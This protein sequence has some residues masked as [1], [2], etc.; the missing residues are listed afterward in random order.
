MVDLHLYRLLVSTE[1]GTDWLSCGPAADQDPCAR[2]APLPNHSPAC[3]P[4]WST[5]GV[6]EM[7]LLHGVALP[8]RCGVSGLRCRHGP[9]LGDGGVARAGDH[10]RDAV[11]DVLGLQ[12][13]GDVLGVG[14]GQVGADLLAV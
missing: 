7:C 13:H 11:S 5:E 3:Q 8:C 9:Q 14:G 10:E 6:S 4:P 2:A 1:D 12:P